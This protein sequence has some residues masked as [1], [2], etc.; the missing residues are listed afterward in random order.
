MRSCSRGNAN[1]SVQTFRWATPTERPCLRTSSRRVVAKC[2]GGVGGWRWRRGEES[3]NVLKVK[4]RGYG[5]VA[6][7]DSACA[8]GASRP[9]RPLSGP[10]RD[11]DGVETGQ[12]VVVRG[13][14]RR[15][16]DDLVA[17][18]AR[19]HRHDDRGWVWLI[20]HPTLAGWDVCRPL[21]PGSHA[22]PQLC[23]ARRAVERLFAI[24]YV[25]ALAPPEQRCRGRTL[26]L[27]WCLASVFMRV[28]AGQLIVPILATL[29]VLTTPVGTGQGVHGSE[30]L[31]PVF[32]H[33]HLINGQIVTDGQ[34]AAARAAL[35]PESVASQSPRGVALGAGSAADAAGLG[36][37]LGPT[38]PLF[39]I[40]VLPALES[41]LPAIGSLVPTEFREPPQD[42]PP[43]HLA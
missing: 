17:H 26:G 3:T 40:A 35:P 30:I 16:P 41:R 21:P 38:V 10:T 42:P 11:L 36:L 24:V 7:P 28:L 31:H 5:A 43:D 19:Q 23:R 25:G 20:D 27:C 34:A 9:D 12:V 18:R 15:V 39:G 2:G 29:L 22:V 6:R 8:R 37:A 14:A 33:S 4:R 13:L 32:P 1:G